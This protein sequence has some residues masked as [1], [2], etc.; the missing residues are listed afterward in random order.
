MS[1]LPVFNI[2][3]LCG[4]FVSFLC[5]PFAAPVNAGNS[6]AGEVW[7]WGENYDGQLGI[8]TNEKSSL[9]VKTSGAGD[10]IAVATGYDGHSLAL[11]ADGTVLAWGDNTCGQLGNGTFEDSSVPVK[12]TGLSNVIAVD[13]GG[14]DSGGCSIA[15]KSDGTV[16]GWGENRDGQLGNGTR[17]DSNVPIRVGEL[18][19]ITAIAAGDD[20][21]MAL[22]ADGTVWAWGENHTH[23]KLGNGSNQDI[24]RGTF[25]S[26]VE[27]NTAVEIDASIE[28]S[29]AVTSDGRVWAWGGNFSGQ[30]GT[31]D[32]EFLEDR[33]TPVT[34]VGLTGVTAIAAGDLHNLALKDDGT[35]WAWGS[36]WDGQLGNGT[37]SSFYS[38]H[39]PVRD[40]SG[41]V[42][43]AAGGTHS[44]ALKQ[45]GTVWAWGGNSSGQLGDG[46]FENKNLPVQVKNITRAS[47]IAAGGRQSF[48]V[49]QPLATPVISSTVPVA[50]SPVPVTISA[51]PETTLAAPLVTTTTPP[52]SSSPLANLPTVPPDP[53]PY[54]NLPL[55]IAAATLMVL[56]LVVVWGVH[57]RRR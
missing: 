33:C 9:P 40:L 18:R 45:D 6:A 42:A 56:S 8:G 5:A 3:C 38:F 26:V 4:A 55:W 37:F 49:A 50:T 52:A 7:A 53:P 28:H 11:K 10:I 16:W 47:A 27:M 2:I 46:T 41:V 34:L 13:T 12:V 35:V 20:Y 22:K 1:R 21:C 44:L 30:L 17:Q 31:T 54:I 23:G 29:L 14:S 48:A 51:P 57:R 43:I 25:V 32:N 24:P 36:N 15:L 19:D 39:M